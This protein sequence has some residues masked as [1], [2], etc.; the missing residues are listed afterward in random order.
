MP[1]QLPDERALGQA[2]NPQPSTSVASYRG[3]T[4][5]EGAGAEALMTAGSEFGKAAEIFGQYQERQNETA[6]NDVYSNQFSPAFRQL[7]Q[8]YKAL[9]GKAAVDAMPV[10]V[11]KMQV[12]R[13]TM[14][15]SLPNNSQ[16]KLFDEYSRRRVEM[17]L[18]NV[19]MHSNTQ[20]KAWQIATQRGTLQNDMSFIADA[21]D[22]NVTFAD[23]LALGRAHIFEYAK[24]NGGIGIS[25]LPPEQEFKAFTSD[26]LVTKMQ[27]LTLTNPLLAEKELADP[28]T[29][30]AIDPKH[31]AL[32]VNRATEAAITV[33]AAANADAWVNEQ[34]ATMPTQLAVPKPSGS[35]GPADFPKESVSERT[36]RVKDSITAYEAELGTVTDPQG[37]TDIQAE[38]ARAKSALVSGDPYIMVGG[39]KQGKPV[40]ELVPM[41][42][43]T[44]GLPN[45]RDVRAQ[46]PILLAKVE[47][48]ATE[49]YGSDP[50]NPKRIEYVAKLTAAISHRIS[51][52][53]AQLDAIQKQAQGTLIDFIAGANGGSPV[54]DESQIFG[55]PQMAQAW[56]R[57]DPQAKLGLISLV[58]TNSRRDAKANDTLYWDVFNRVH[59]PIGDPQKIEFYQQMLEYAGPG[60]LNMQQVKELRAEIDRNETPGGRSVGQIMKGA[61]ASVNSF[62]RSNVY[63]SGQPEK[64]IAATMRWTESASKKI[65]EYVA[66]KKDVRSLF[67]VDSKDSIV[68]PA[69]LQTYVNST[70]AQGLAE[71]AAQV[72]RGRIGEPAKPRVSAPLP[73]A[74]NP[75]TG[76][77]QVFKDGKWQKP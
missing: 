62:F 56:Q 53:G 60:K 57:T 61:S 9:Q 12:L 40:A 8:G 26:A 19:A 34:L 29:V 16:K 77:T 39:K 45:S 55:N 44:S 21:P 48:Q 51:K 59:L 41:P 5:M 7:Y 3:T 11:E 36:Q 65:D 30:Q 17:E 25:G 50:T 31:R 28:A 32:V 38:I 74:V 58:A 42:P 2:P 70:P 49:I 10:V 33:R 1:P 24:A 72:S 63:F 67:M 18:D 14:R 22:N 66:E 54:T 76:E 20:N 13:T 4:G 23:S 27:A 69:Y 64:A 71:Q 43:D 47:P 68:S 15:D 6:A 52:E 37:R 73:T 46:L 75:K 35:V